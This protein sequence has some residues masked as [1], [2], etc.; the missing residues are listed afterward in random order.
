M[1]KLKRVKP[2]IQRMKNHFER[3]TFKKLKKYGKVE[4]EDRP[5]SYIINRIYN[6]DFSLSWL[7]N[8]IYQLSII[9]TKGYF[10]PEDRQKQKLIK[11]QY[12]DLDIRILFLADNKINRRSKTRYSDWC[13]QQG[14]AYAIREIPKDWFTKADSIIEARQTKDAQYST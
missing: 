6:P 7:C 14:I 3:T 2:D 11:E 5:L 1:N 8:G 13:Q 12:P 4:Y 9:E 10:S